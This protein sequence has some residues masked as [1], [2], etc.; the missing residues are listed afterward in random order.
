MY[1]CMYY[2]YYYF[3]NSEKPKSKITHSCFKE[4]VHYYVNY[5]YYE[6]LY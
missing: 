3:F 2:N 4:D 5:Y 1:V 6:Q